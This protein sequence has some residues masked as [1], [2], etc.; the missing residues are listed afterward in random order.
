[1]KSM[2]KKVALLLSLVLL[3]SF[4]PVAFADDTDIEYHFATFDEV[5]TSDFNFAS[6]RTDYDLGLG[7]SS[8]SDGVVATYVANQSAGPV[9]YDAD[10]GVNGTGAIVL[11]AF[12]NDGKQTLI[13][14]NSV[15]VPSGGVI[16]FSYDFCALLPSDS[17]MANKFTSGTTTEGKFYLGTTNGTALISVSY[18][19]GDWKF[20]S[21]D[22][23]RTA[24]VPTL[25]LSTDGSPDASGSYFPASWVV[26]GTGTDTA[27]KTK[28][29]HL[30]VRQYSD[31]KREGTVYDLETGEA[32]FTETVSS[33]SSST[34]FNFDI[35]RMERCTN[36]GGEAAHHYRKTTIAYDNVTL[37]VYN[38]TITA[39][40]VRSEDVEA[41]EVAR[42]ATF[43][44][45]FSQP[46][47]GTII[48]KEKVSGNTVTTTTTPLG[49]DK[50]KLSWTGLLAKGTEYEI[51]FENVTNGTLA[52]GT[53]PITFTTED[54]HLW[55]DVEISPVSAGSG[56]MSV[57]FTVSDELEYPLFTGSMLVAAY[58]NGSLIGVDMVVLTNEDTTQAITK[59]VNLGTL[60]Q[61]A[62][63]D[64]I[65]LDVDTGAVPLAMGTTEVQ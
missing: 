24:A 56:A 13:K 4:M 28:W 34:S 35:S 65:L 15:T 45:G 61:G 12:G 5:R 33:Y 48:L 25:S 40:E 7:L 64:I 53:E 3:I 14:T 1:M 16:E 2:K 11:T 58:K 44:F 30:V 62:T 9:A 59:T 50:L 38:P 60:P 26:V 8:K 21:A 22:G 55:N 47:S 57:S 29:L 49:A 52:C 39:P 63:L 6:S 32:L 23:T 31:G 46:V 43:T 41:E 18:V 10:G 27:Q 37:R 42:N 54:L 36:A 20:V 51:S 19:G 17:F